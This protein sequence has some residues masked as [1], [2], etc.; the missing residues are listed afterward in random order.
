ML[1]SIWPILTDP[2]AFLSSSKIILFSPTKT[3]SP[4]SASVDC[5]RIV[6]SFKLGLVIGVGQVY[7][8]A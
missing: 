3:S 7:I 6:L 5:R 1:I 2:I 8:L 4:I